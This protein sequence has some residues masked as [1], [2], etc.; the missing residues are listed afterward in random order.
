MAFH[1]HCTSSAQSQPQS[2]HDASTPASRP[3]EACTPVTHV[4]SIAVVASSTEAKA[5]G[6][7]SLPLKITDKAERTW[8]DIGTGSCVY[9]G[10]I[11]LIVCVMT[12]V[13]I[14]DVCAGLCQWLLGVMFWS[15][16]LYAIELSWPTLYA[17]VIRWRWSTSRTCTWQVSLSTEAK[18]KPSIETGDTES[19][20]ARR[21]AFADNHDPPLE[22]EVHNP[23]SSSTP[24][25]PGNEM[26][27]EEARVS[28]LSP[29][30]NLQP[31]TEHPPSCG[32][33]SPHQSV[34]GS[35]AGDTAYPDKETVIPSTLTPAATTK[36]EAVANVDRPRVPLNPTKHSDVE[37]CDPSSEFPGTDESRERRPKRNA[38]ARAYLWTSS[39]YYILYSWKIAFN[40]WLYAK[41][42]NAQ[43]PSASRHKSTYD[44]PY[45][46]VK[47]RRW[48]KLVVWPIYL[49]WH[50]G[51]DVV[52][53]QQP[54]D[55]SKPYRD[56][57]RIFG[58]SRF[59]EARRKQALISLNVTVFIHRE[60]DP[61]IP[62]YV[63]ALISFHW[64][65][66]WGGNFF[67]TFNRGNHNGT[68]NGGTHGFGG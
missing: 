45:T 17:T 1:A 59:L 52:H 4:P 8:V 6:S 39:I 42:C 57:S 25:L 47:G 56:F 51:F 9:I 62:G 24:D 44:A 12:A 20:Q 19:K 48:W 55:G 46:R 61:T 23:T 28:P 49:E 33:S 35:T 40:S 3:Q 15:L 21:G 60:R 67:K 30:D 22:H 58:D 68:T 2:R 14:L 7:S 26:S 66:N 41:L 34:S 54:R 5:N 18:P 53:V 13:H 65:W 10:L 64:N 38:Y 11:G 32:V 27:L 63:C 31:P 36:I 43:I 29:R 50:S 37:Q 16:V